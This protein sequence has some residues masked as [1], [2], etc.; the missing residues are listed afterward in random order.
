MNQK[1][2]GFLTTGLTA[3]V[4]LAVLIMGVFPGTVNAA[5]VNEPVIQIEHNL[6]I[7]FSDGVL[8]QEQK[9][10]YMTI[11]QFQLNWQQRQ[12]SRTVGE[13][14]Q[15]AEDLVLE[16]ETLEVSQVELDSIWHC[17]L[18]LDT[19][20]SSPFG[21]RLHPVYGYYKMH[22]GVDL[23]SDRGDP[24]LAARGGTVVDVGYSSTAGKYIKI[25]HGDGFI[26]VYYHL[27][28]QLV[29]E[30]QRV[31]G[32]ELIGKVGNTGVS[33]GSHLHFG[34]KYEGKYVDPEDYVD[35]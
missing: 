25:D 30:G 9:A 34:V 24:V 17:P 12:M 18:A 22:N 28:Q 32:G 13:A 8:T 5:T 31:F 20:V 4:M 27:S 1:I 21:M 35:F 7:D 26:T 23:D 10:S 14:E 33:T 3:A 16:P 2:W 15:A 19:Y 29:K 6:A 11:K